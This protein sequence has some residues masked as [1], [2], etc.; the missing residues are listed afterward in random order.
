MA[1]DTVMDKENVK[2]GAEDTDLGDA[3]VHHED[4]GGKLFK[5]HSVGTAR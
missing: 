3:C 2:H 1:G 5:A 4:V